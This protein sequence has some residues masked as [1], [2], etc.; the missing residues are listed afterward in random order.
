MSNLLEYAVQR[1]VKIGAAQAEAFYF[2]EDK[3]QTTIEKSQVKNCEKKSDAGVGLRVALKKRGGYS[4]GFSY[5]TDLSKEAAAKT[6]QKT[7]KIASFK[8]P[9]RDLASFQEHKPAA[10]I[11]K[12]HDKAI[13]RLEPETIVDL[14]NSLVKTAS[15]DKRIMTIGG[16]INLSAGQVVLANSLGFSGDY[17]FSRYNTGGYVVAQDAGSVAVGWDEYSDCFFNED[18]AYTVFKNAP[19]NA[20]SQ[21]HPKAIKTEKM[22]LLIQPP[23]L[24]ML[25]GTTLM[26]AV[27]ADN[28]QKSQSPFVGKLGHSVASD[29]VSIVDDG[30]VP[31]AFGSRPFDDEGFPTQ[32]TKIIDKGVLR[33]FLHNI[34]T[35]SKDKVESTGNSLRS[36]GGFGT[37]QR[38]CVEPQIGS[39]N[40]KLSPGTKSAE[41]NIDT[42]MREVRNGVIAKGVIGAH[43]ANPQSG[44]FSVA[45]DLAYKVEKGD[46]SFPVKQAMIGGNVQDLLKNVSLLADD[47]TH[48]GWEHT[49]II[50]PTVLVKNVTVSG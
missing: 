8:K 44:E 42:V 16:R 18:S 36:M 10:Q 40:L 49:S 19:K 11:K 21:L 38:Y 9:D 26:S 27:R 28:V 20:L 47:V 50:T 22:D 7:L 32:A 25:L 48:A 43:T 31:Q 37:R 34:Y 41:G 29:S 17:S 46:I 15:V 12:I 23:A 30:H 35:S 3:F 24:A 1:A 13:M 6:A 5:F 14:A 33:S 39:T 45:L 2:A 4:T